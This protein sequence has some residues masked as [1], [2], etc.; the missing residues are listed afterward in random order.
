[1]W[2]VDVLK[3]VARLWLRLADE[4]DEDSPVLVEVR[5]E[6]QEVVGMLDSVMQTY[7]KDVDWDDEVTQLKAVDER[8]NELVRSHRTLNSTELQR[9]VRS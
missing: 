3:R 4:G 9:R 7:K 5:G 6:C 1:M 2:R 8:L